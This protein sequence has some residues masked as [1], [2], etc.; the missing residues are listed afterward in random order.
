MDAAVHRLVLKFLNE[1]VR[2]DDLR[3]GKP[4]SV[5]VHPNDP[6]PEHHAKDED[7]KRHEIIKA[8]A[9][10]EIMEFRETRYPLGFRHWRELLELKNFRFEILDRL[11]SLF[12]SSVMGQWNEFP[13]DIPQRGPGGISGVVHAALLKSGQVLFITAD[14]TTLLWDPED[15][16]PSTWEDPVNQPHTMPNGYSQLCGHHVQLSDSNGSLLSVGG[17]GYGPN[18]L[19]KAGYIFDPVAKQWR[20]SAN[21]MVN[22]KWYPTAVSLGGKKVLVA[23]G[24]NTTDDMEIFDENSE[25]FSPIAGDDRTFPNI[26]PGLHILPNNAIFY[27]RTGFGTAGAGPGGTSYDD[28]TVNPMQLEGKRPAYF[29]FNPGYTGGTWQKITTSP[30]N[31]TKGMSVVLNSPTPPYVRV[32]VVGGADAAS[33]DTYEIF[34]AST[35]TPAASFDPWQPVPDGENRSLCSLVLLPD[36]NVFVCGGISSTNSPCTMFDP[37]TNTWSAKANLPSARQYHS[38]AILLP[39]GKVMMAGWYNTKIE[40]YSP[41]YLFKG[42]RPQITTAPSLVHHGAAFSIESPQA[43]TIAK[44]VFVRPMAVT[45]QT[46]S[47]QRVIDVLPLIYDPMT[48]T[49]I[50]LT[51]PDGGHPHPMAP[52]GHYMMFAIDINGIPSVAEWIY[53]H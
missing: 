8:A 1:A 51:A 45:H 29:T 3:F 42:A 22:H 6:H 16:T 31:R 27:S 20:R 24:R 32:L 18:A 28:D 13:Q 10:K 52:R 36:G 26:Y 53:L 34:D 50:N 49:T 15:P 48:P 2:P 39:S 38:V 44:V 9:A 40:I 46:D 12:S 37:Q 33:N 14:E 7:H 21:D 11:V 23:S 17:G 35:L 43:A 25:T 5:H 41:P 19:A 30:I 4:T 47:E